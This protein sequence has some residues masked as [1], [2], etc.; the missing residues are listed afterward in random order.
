MR[1]TDVMFLH[2]CFLSAYSQRHVIR[3]TPKLRKQGYTEDIDL[4]DLLSEAAVDSP[5][6][7]GK[8]CEENPSCHSAMMMG[9]LCRLFAYR[10]QCPPKPAVSISMLVTQ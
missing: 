1:L 7:C 4:G 10:H 5:E 8:L 9:Q 2:A 6:A 3:L